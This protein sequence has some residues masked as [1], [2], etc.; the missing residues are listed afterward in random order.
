MKTYPDYITRKVDKI[1]IEYI[2]KLNNNTYLI[3]A[4]RPY[5]IIKPTMRV[6]TVYYIIREFDQH[7][8]LDLLVDHI[9]EEVDIFNVNN[10]LLTVHRSI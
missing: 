6:R 7:I 3:D 4:L 9:E 1:V 5:S 8:N 2:E 10:Y